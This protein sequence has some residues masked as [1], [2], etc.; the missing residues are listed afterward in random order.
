MDFKNYV[1]H[2]LSPRDGAIFAARFVDGRS[3]AEICRN[4]GVE[5]STVYE[6]LRVIRDLFT[7][8]IDDIGHPNL[9]A[10]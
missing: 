2:A 8:F 10:S 6:R 9:H 4:T 7:Q 1:S 5:K 3:I